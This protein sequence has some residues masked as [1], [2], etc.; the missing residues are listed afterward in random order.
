MPP[1]GR[2]PPAQGPGYGGV[3]I[4]YAGYLGP[5]VLS[6]PGKQMAVYATS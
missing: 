3:Q 6:Q 4:Y 2:F 1:H 5:A